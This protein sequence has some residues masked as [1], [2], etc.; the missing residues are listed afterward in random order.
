V[1]LIT[2]KLGT[3]DQSYKSLS[4]LSDEEIHDLKQSLNSIRVTN[5]LA[6]WFIYN[7]TLD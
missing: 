4:F 6:D 1:F 2:S 5:G 7:E 3:I